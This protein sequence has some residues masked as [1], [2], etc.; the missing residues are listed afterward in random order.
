M[1]KLHLVENVE[2]VFSQSTSHTV[3]LI[4]ISIT[5]SRNAVKAYERVET[6]RS[7]G[8]RA[9]KAVWEKAAAPELGGHVQRG[10]QVSVNTAL[11]MLCMV[12]SVCL[13]ICL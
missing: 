10:C 9:L 2:K 6:S 13:Y 11:Q 8:Q 12:I 1:S 3:Y 7:S 5:R 4:H